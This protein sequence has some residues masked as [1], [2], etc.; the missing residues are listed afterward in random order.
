MQITRLI[1]KNFQTYLELDLDLRVEPERPIVLI[2]GANGGGKTTLFNA[3]C[4]ALYGLSIPD[5]AAFRKKVNAGVLVGGGDEREMEIKLEIH[6]TGKVLEQTQQYI[7]SRS[8]ELFEDS[9]RY[10]VALNMNGNIIRYGSATA[11]AERQA[12]ESQVVKIIKANLPRELSEYFLFDA[13]S[14]GQKLEEEQLSRVIRENIEIVMG[15]RKYLELAKAARRVQE[16]KAAERLKAKAEREEYIRLTDEKRMDSEVLERLQGERRD[17]RATLHS[18]SE[19][20]QELR[21]TQDQESFLKSRRE[22]L[23]SQRQEILDKE[24][25]YRAEIQGFIKDLA[26][27]IGLPQLSKQLRAEIGQIL[28]ACEDG[29]GAGAAFPREVVAHVVDRLV[30]LLGERSPGLVLPPRDELVQAVLGDCAGAS[31]SP[32]A[33]LDKVELGALSDLLRLPR[34]NPFGALDIIR[35]ELAS[36]IPALAQLDQQID[37]LTAQ[38]AGKDY[39]VL[40]RFE[41]CERLEAALSRDIERLEGEIREKER[42]IQRY[43]IQLQDEPDPRYEALCRLAGYFEAAADALLK[44]KKQQIEGQMLKDLNINLAAYRNVIARVELSENLRSLS[45]RIF[46]KA[47]NEIYLD[48]LNA[49]SKQV[50][51]QVLLKALHEHGDYDPPVMIDTVMGVL[52]RESRGIML[53]HYFPSLAQ[54]A[55]LL[56]TDSEIDPE[57]DFEKIAA[58]VSTA[59]T[60]IRDKDAQRTLVEPGYFGVTTE[61]FA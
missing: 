42:K 22:Q 54:Q 31:Q 51:V 50:V 44:A 56:S 41:E 15:F 6:F 19:L 14:A 48:Q 16:T 29:G 26:V 20:V 28:Q 4:G 57:R 13:M 47:G 36:S 55:I 34:A 39:T 33:F 52:D 1:A 49:A 18:N 30:T 25:R 32:W 11:A 7:L 2:G 5:A 8:W 17:C 10:A 35:R 58:F 53:E 40:K 43:D 12:A 3:L 46:H 9:V 24:Q 21:R 38:M 59:Y 61:E 37:D 23:Q 60:L 45:F 27:T